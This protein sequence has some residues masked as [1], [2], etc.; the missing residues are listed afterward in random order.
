MVGSLVI[1]TVV[2]S[3]VAGLALA[4]D[5]SPNLDDAG[6]PPNLSAAAT[7]RAMTRRSAGDGRYVVFV[8]EASNLTRDSGR[9]L[10]QVYSRDIVN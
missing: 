6:L 4:D 3:C 2:V 10:A 8:S 7:A 9:H 1:C 5:R